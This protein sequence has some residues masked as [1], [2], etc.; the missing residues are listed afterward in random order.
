M[1]KDIFNKI[2]SIFSNKNKQTFRKRIFS[3]DQVWKNIKIAFL[4]SFALVIFFGVAIF[5]AVDRGFFSG[6]AKNIG[7]LVTEINKNQIEELTKILDQKKYNFEYFKT[8]ESEV[9]DPYQN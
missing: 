7:T 9:V 3:P 8:S 4:V 2:K 6:E 5:V 1:N